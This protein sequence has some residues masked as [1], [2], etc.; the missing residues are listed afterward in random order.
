MLLSGT[1]CAGLTE[2]GAG[3]TSRPV[4]P[5]AAAPVR[6]PN[7]RVPPIAAGCD[8]KFGDTGVEFL[9]NGYT[10][11]KEFEPPAGPSDPEAAL[12][13]LMRALAGPMAPL[14]QK[15]GAKMKEAKFDLRLAGNS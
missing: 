15:V 4:T 7:W 1:G 13:A 9:C 6:E 8:Q 10:A 5:S 14:V 11:S 12:D 2:E 3:S